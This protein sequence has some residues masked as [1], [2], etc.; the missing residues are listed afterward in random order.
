MGIKEL[1]SAMKANPPS[2]A[3]PNMLDE[4][5]SAYGEGS[6]KDYNE[7]STSKIGNRPWRK[8]YSRNEEIINRIGQMLAIQPKDEYRFDLGPTMNKDREFFPQGIISGGDK[9]V[10][11]GSYIESRGESDFTEE[12]D[13]QGDIGKTRS[14]SLL[15][16]ILKAY[17]VHQNAPQRR[18]R[19]EQGYPEGQYG[20]YQGYSETE[21]KEKEFIKTL[22]G[23]KRTKT[24]KDKHD[25]YK[26]STSIYK[27]L[28]G[29]ESTLWPEVKFTAKAHDS[30]DSQI[31]YNDISSIA[32]KFSTY[33]P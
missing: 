20:L 10:S 6:D 7:R 19:E 30:I 27:D 14:S 2:D 31:A 13:F 29:R 25:S 15:K 26:V 11:P 4:I 24:T 9:L 12:Q 28:L 32:K 21:E 8:G 18:L 3:I 17:N 1:I 22:F 33:K 23:N 16:S 5:V